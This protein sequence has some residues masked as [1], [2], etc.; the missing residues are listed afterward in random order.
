MSQNHLPLFSWNINKIR[1]PRNKA[2]TFV[3]VTVTCYYTLCV[4]VFVCVYDCHMHDYYTLC[5]CVYNYVCVVYSY[6][7]QPM[8]MYKD[9]E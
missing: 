5:V 6:A 2:N 7:N 1:E 4:H 8:Y 3:Y 9:V